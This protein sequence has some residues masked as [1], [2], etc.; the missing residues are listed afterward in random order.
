MRTECEQCLE[1]VTTR[2]TGRDRLLFRQRMGFK[3]DT[4][5]NDGMSLG[6]LVGRLGQHKK[7]LRQ[8]DADAA[9]SLFE[10]EPGVPGRGVRPELHLGTY[11]SAVL[12]S[13][14][15]CG[16]GLGCL[17]DVIGFEERRS[18]LL[19]ESLV[20]KRRPTGSTRCWKHFHRLCLAIH[21][22]ALGLQRLGQLKLANRERTSDVKVPSQT[23]WERNKRSEASSFVVCRRA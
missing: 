13:R 2:A 19:A 20:Y 15:G 6:G 7:K 17:V 3:V 12:V 8:A 9:I 21:G 22:N 5:K 14:G 18:L 16:G 4:L 10:K 23:T 1:R 11:G